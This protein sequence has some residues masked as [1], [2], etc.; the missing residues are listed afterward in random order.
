M[1]EQD[2]TSTATPAIALKVRVSDSLIA[3]GEGTAASSF[4][5]GPTDAGR[6][7]ESCGER[8]DIGKGGLSLRKVTARERGA[9]QARL[10]AEEKQ[11]GIG[12]TQLD[13]QR[14]RASGGAGWRIWNETEP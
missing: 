12:A 10:F 13:R 7:W 6:S 11:D 9:K 8:T 2:V 14:N 5:R 3:G 1:N 4:N